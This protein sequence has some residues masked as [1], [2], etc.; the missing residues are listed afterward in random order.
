MQNF[1][2]GAN[3]FGRPGLSGSVLFLCLLVSISTSTA[4]TPHDTKGQEFWVAFM[5]N[6]GSGGD[7]ELSDLR[8][9][10]SS[11]SITTVYIHYPPLGG[12]VAIPVTRPRVPVE[13]NI[14]QLFGDDTELKEVVADGRNAISQ[15]SFHITSD[16]DITLYGVN[17]RNKS[18]DAFLALPDDVLSGNYIVNAW[19]NGRLYGSFGGTF[20]DE[21]DTHSEF[22]VIATENGTTVTITPSALL[23][24]RKNKDRFSVQLNEGDVYF[25]QA[26]LG[27]P[28]DVTGTQI[29]ANKPVAVYAGNERTAI[30]I[31]VG[32]YR[33]HLV[34]Q[35][36]PIEAWGNS[37]LLTPHFNIAPGST[38]QSEAR[39]LAAFDNT[40]V[41]VVTAAGPRT[42]QLDAATPLRLDLEAASVVS[43]KPIM[44]TQFE[45]SVGNVSGLGA[46]NLGDPF[47]MLIPPPEQYDT[48]YSFQSVV[49]PEFL[50]HYINVIVPEDLVESLQIDGEDISNATFNPV[51]GTDFVYAQ[52]RVN[53]GS[54]YI[55]ADDRFGLCVYGFGDAISYGYP[56]GTLFRELVLDFEHPLINAQQICDLLEGMVVDDRLT[57]SGVDSCYGLSSSTNVRI[58][59]EPFKAGAD[60]VRWHAELIDPYQDGI[61]EIK[62]VD[63]AGRSS[64]IRKEM[65]GFTVAANEEN[66]GEPVEVEVVTFNGKKACRTFQI[67]NYGKYPQTISRLEVSP[68]DVPGLQLQ[69]S[70]SFQLEPGEI[71]EIQV[72]YEG[73]IDQA[74]QVNLVVGDDCTERSV[75]RAKIISVIDTLPPSLSNIS[76]GC[77][78]AAVTFTEP[79][80]PYLEIESVRIDTIINGR[81]DSESGA[82]PAR[83]LSLRFTPQ[84]FREDMI[85][86]ATVFDRGGNSITF[87][88]TVPG[89][90]VAVREQPESDR[91]AIRL[92]RDW[93]SDSIGLNAERCDSLLLVNYGSY[94]LTITRV[95]MKENFDFSIPPSQLPVSLAPGER[96]RFAVCLEGRIAGEQ[97]DTLWIE[98]ACGR[99][100]NVLLRT[101]VQ[102]MAGQGFDQ[103]GTLVHLEAFG[104]AK[105]TFLATPAPNPSSAGILTVDIGLQSE[106]PVALR[107]INME[108]ITELE[109]VSGEEIEAGV[110]RLTFDA[111]QLSSGIYYCLMETGS[112]EI[113]TA[114]FMIRD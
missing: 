29:K 62:A 58:D 106:N 103:C 113:R 70:S 95:F 17:I 23:S 69:D 3:P 32:N 71:K 50:R 109:F 104:P 34:E 78:E 1:L 4:Q 77:G 42:W 52:I 107:V 72:C 35:L 98:D 24:G 47:M 76:E 111:S 101:P 38:Y 9:Y 21:F 7:F 51:P 36:P 97:I 12:Q 83:T 46:T 48:A 15:N 85:V 20:I 82:L 8:L 33:D 25:G 13:V 86:R 57:D 100:E 75:V 27:L 63:G 91:L 30:P 81:W 60:T 68:S 26:V 53:P 5:E 65:P 79:D 67:H 94:P 16:H 22:A 45:H 31:S 14:R 37:A 18:S 43:D 66:E 19:P 93:T 110:H 59:I 92:E 41:T 114:K 90:T 73:L 39:I 89:F 99:W 74:A 80:E 44:T 112:G 64:V 49:H 61:A 54:H 56:G 10:F 108:G 55:R 11:D 96:R 40:S 84:D 28:E 2:L 6:L 105:R 102:S 88:D 87:A